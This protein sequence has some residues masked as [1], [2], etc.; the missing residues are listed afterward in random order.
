MPN[1]GNHTCVLIAIPLPCWSNDDD[2]MR[3]ESFFVKRW[4]QPIEEHRPKEL[5]DKCVMLSCPDREF[6]SV[7]QLRD[8]VVFH[9]AASGSRDAIRP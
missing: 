9:V 5:P 1:F 2:I 4:R 6:P 7:K 3:L 8:V